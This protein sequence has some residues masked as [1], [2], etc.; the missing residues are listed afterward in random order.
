MNQHVPI[1]ESNC[2]IMANVLISWIPLI[3]IQRHPFLT[4]KPIEE[5]KCDFGPPLLMTLSGACTDG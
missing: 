5:S 1:H 2:I 4:P 3:L